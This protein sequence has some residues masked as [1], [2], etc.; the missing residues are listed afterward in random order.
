MRREDELKID[1]FRD[2]LDRFGSSLSR[3]PFRDLRD[4]HGLLST[5]PAAREAHLRSLRLERGI[6]A[7]RP[8]VARD[9]AHAVVARAM[10]EIVPWHLEPP[11]ARDTLPPMLA[12]PLARAGFLLAV[13]ALG[14]GIGI[15]WGSPGSSFAKE[16]GPENFVTANMDDAG[17]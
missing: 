1:A 9:R 7:S 8:F 3:W 16:G 5:N 6:A 11:H 2:R 15:E 14:Y 4:G 13:T 10:N 12:G 17:N